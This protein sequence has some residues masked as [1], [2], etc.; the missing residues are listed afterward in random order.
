M[1]QRKRLP[2]FEILL[3]LFIL[4]AV[5]FKFPENHQK[6]LEFFLNFFTRPYFSNTLTLEAGVLDR[7]M[8]LHLKG[9]K[10]NF[11]TPQKN[12]PIEILEIHS[13]NPVTELFW[14][15]PLR[16]EFRG[17]RVQTSPY[18]GVEGVLLF[19]SGRNGFLELRAKII[20]MGLEE[21]RWINPELLKNSH[22]KMAGV[23]VLLAT[24]DQQIHY[25]LSLKFR[26][27]GGEIPAEFLN[28][29]LAYLPPIENQPRVNIQGSE[30]RLVHYREA[31]VRAASAGIGKMKV[32]LHAAIPDYNLN[33]NLNL[34]LRT[35]SDNFFQDIARI[36]GQFEAKS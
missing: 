23:L 7:G 8:K 4:C 3:A 26:E 19:Q 22:G 12:L 25:D 11:H 13:L 6:T 29:L 18:E 10:A 2:F 21:L 15:I 9:L 28:L 33:L 34:D 1:V 27:P 31:E 24:A 30:A 16:F 32:F 36:M 35:D 20:G 5:F 14:G 17:A